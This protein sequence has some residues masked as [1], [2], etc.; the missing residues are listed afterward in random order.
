M[1]TKNRI[2]FTRKLAGL[3]VAVLIFAA[4]TPAR[5]VTG[6]RSRYQASRTA[7]QLMAVR[8]EVTKLQAES[9][10]FIKITVKPAREFSEVTV[11]AKENDP[12]GSAVSHESGSDLLGLL[13]DED[14]QESGRIT[15]AELQEGDIVS[16][17]Y[18]PLSQNRALEIYVH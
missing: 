15:A 4:S 2:V 17:I 18:D 12:V 6:P 5:T 1:G 13:S 14:S 8:G 9:G 10:G 11:S 16:V 7:K 3:G